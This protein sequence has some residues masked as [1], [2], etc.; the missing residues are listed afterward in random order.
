MR[1]RGVKNEEVGADLLGPS[2][3]ME[4]VPL[5]MPVRTYHAMLEAAGKIGCTAA[6]AFEKALGEFLE[7]VNKPAPPEPVKPQMTNI[8]APLIVKK[9]R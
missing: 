2:G 7:K 9:K 6:Q 4:F 5:F 8:P 3:D 1:V